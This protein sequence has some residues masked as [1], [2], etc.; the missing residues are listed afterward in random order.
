M[1][2]QVTYVPGNLQLTGGAVGNG[3]L[4]VDG[5]LDI[6]GGLEFYGLIIVRGVIS[7]TGG[8]SSGVNIYGA[9]LAGQQSYVDT[10]LG[11]SANIYFDFCSLP[12]GSQNQ[13]PRMLS[14]RELIM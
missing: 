4:I 5:N 7:F 6:H 1:S 8:G 11:G 10:T 12:Q 13:P 3:V 2:R 14:F 9:V